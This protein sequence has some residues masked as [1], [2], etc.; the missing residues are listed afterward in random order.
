M[1]IL[2]E[3]VLC[4]RDTIPVGALSAQCEPV[5]KQS[6]RPF[7]AF[8]LAHEELPLSRPGTLDPRTYL[9]RRS[10]FQPGLVLISRER[11]GVQLSKNSSGSFWSYCHGLWGGAFTLPPLHYLIEG[12]PLTL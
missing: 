11:A 4:E 9:S 2:N 6:T 3:P 1:Q 5:L 8:S 10:T 7:E 12:R